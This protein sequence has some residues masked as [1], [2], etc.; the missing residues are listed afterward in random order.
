MEVSLIITHYRSPQVLKLS[1]GYICN[2]KKNFEG[3]VE[4]IV[5]D[6]DTDSNTKQMMQE[7][8]PDV[9]LLTSDKN[10]GFGKA[11]NKGLMEATGKY[12]VIM[13]SDVI[14]PE[15]KDITYMLE[16][17][18]RN[19]D[20]GL[21]GPKLLNFDNTH[22]PSAF[23]YYSPLS[24]LF[25]RTVLGK[26]KLGKRKIKEFTMD[27]VE[28]LTETPTEVD[29]LMGSML[30]TK[31]EYLDEVGY[32]DERFFMYME[33]VDL[34]KRFWEVGKK[35]VYYPLSNVYHFHGK[36]SRTKNIFS[37]LLNKYTRTHLISAF[38]YFKKHGLKTPRYGK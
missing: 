14:V 7:R 33:D 28:D 16:Y 30:V 19:P 2:W 10:I 6:S 15:P 37:A 13:N 20:I 36:A 21:V 5:S 9:K 24:I 12:I 29:W 27:D 32:F 38:K 35:V 26:T 8:Y 1:L 11:V 34:C 22:Q 31:R 17:L 3:D 4:I 18:E 23:R 25:R